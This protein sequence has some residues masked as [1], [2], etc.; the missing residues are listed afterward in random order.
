MWNKPESLQGWYRV[1]Q[2]SLHGTHDL[3]GNGVQVS[4]QELFP[5]TFEFHEHDAVAELGMAC[6]HAP[7]DDDGATVEPKYDANA[8]AE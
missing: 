7:A 6:D 8:D 3:A 4:F 5:L 2:P 1:A